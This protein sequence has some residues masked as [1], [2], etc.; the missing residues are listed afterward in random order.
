MSSTTKRRQHKNSFAA[1]IDDKS[2]LQYSREIYH[3][4]G[5]YEVVDSMSAEYLNGDYSD[6]YDDTYDG[7]IGARDADS[8]D[9]LF[10]R[11]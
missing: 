2:H 1:M 4:H 5:N 6:E 3:R 11:R 8:A 7:L 9:E 10:S